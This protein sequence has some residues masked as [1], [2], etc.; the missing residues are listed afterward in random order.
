MGNFCR[1]MQTIMKC[2][3]E[4][5]EMKSMMSEMKILQRAYQLTDMEKGKEISTF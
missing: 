4:I 5:L 2:P 3:V 1:Q